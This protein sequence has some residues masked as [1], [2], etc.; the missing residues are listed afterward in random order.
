[1]TT[2]GC[3]GEFG[4]RGLFTPESRYQ[5]LLLEF[6]KENDEIDACNARIDREQ[7]C[8]ENKKKNKTQRLM[9]CLWSCGGQKQAERRWLASF[10]GSG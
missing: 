3:Q 1:M 7:V 6:Q 5:S 8:N 10:I 4:S 9:V 2:D